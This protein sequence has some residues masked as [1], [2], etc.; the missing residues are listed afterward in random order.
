ME[1]IFKYKNIEFKKACIKNDLVEIVKN[2]IY[3]NN[4]LSIEKIAEYYGLN[5]DIIFIYKD[6]IL[7]ANT[8]FSY[9][10]NSFDFV[11]KEFN[12]NIDDKDIIAA[13]FKLQLHLNIPKE[14]TYK[15][16]KNYDKD[17][18]MM[19]EKLLESEEKECVINKVYEHHSGKEYVLLTVT[20]TQATKSDYIKTA[21]YADKE[22]VTWSRPLQEFLDN[23]KET[24]K[25]PWIKLS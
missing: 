15:V 6:N 12:M 3:L 10:S 4:A 14:L 7:V 2:G 1:I 5:G 9:Q 17:E 13:F 18:L 21:V 8:Y 11:Y 24:D 19:I 20:N 23:F 16:F 22:L 25:D